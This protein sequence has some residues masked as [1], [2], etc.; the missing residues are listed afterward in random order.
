MAAPFIGSPWAF[1]LNVGRGSEEQWIYRR[2]ALVTRLWDTAELR[3]VWCSVSGPRPSTSLQSKDLRPK[4]HADA[5]RVIPVLDKRERAFIAV[6]L[7]AD[8]PWHRF[9]TTV[10]NG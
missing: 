10:T 4:D 9:L 2:D 1:D 8:H 3:T 6:H 7:V 5:E